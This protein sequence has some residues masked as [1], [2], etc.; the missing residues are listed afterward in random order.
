[1]CLL[2]LLLI[3]VKVRIRCSNAD[4]EGLDV[5]LSYLFISKLLFP[6]IPKE[7]DL[8]DFNIKKFRKNKMGFFKKK[9]AHDKT[10]KTKEK[11]DL[12]KNLIDLK[13]YKPLELVAI[14]KEIVLYFSKRFFG[15]LGIEVNRLQIKVGTE[16]AAKTAML[17]GALSQSV[18]YVLNLFDNISRLKTVKSDAVAVKAD[19]CSEKCLFEADISLKIKPLD[20]LALALGTAWKAYKKLIKEKKSGGDKNVGNQQDQ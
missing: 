11:K 8:N 18:S 5:R 20:A 9:K 13:S 12:L 6:E 16:D 17:Y 3:P 10:G 15:S 7:I 4:G 1:L 14:V 19:F 2:L